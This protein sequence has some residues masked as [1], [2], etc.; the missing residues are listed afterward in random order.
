[1]IEQ[2]ILSGTYTITKYNSFHEFWCVVTLCFLVLFW[3]EIKF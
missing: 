2:D 1:M 3:L